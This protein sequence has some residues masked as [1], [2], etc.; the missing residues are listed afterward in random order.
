M[1]DDW[2]R[3]IGEHLDRALDQHLGLHFD[4]TWHPA[5]QKRHRLQK[6][7]VLVAGVA[8]AGLAAVIIPWGPH[9]KQSRL[10]FSHPSFMA[11]TLPT[12][13]KHLV[14]TL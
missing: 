13:V 7:S 8:A 9:Y 11:R 3:V 2:D 1:S 4:T 6:W 12:G 14:Q 10:S 5:R